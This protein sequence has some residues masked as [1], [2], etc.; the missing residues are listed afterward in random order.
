[1]LAFNYKNCS[2]LA[3]GKMLIVCI[4]CHQARCGVQ[5]G[6]AQIRGLLGKGLEMAYFHYEFCLAPSF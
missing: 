3:L 5:T 1:M 2:N 4:F 6:G